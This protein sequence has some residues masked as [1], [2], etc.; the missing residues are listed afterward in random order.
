[1]MIIDKNNS[2]EVQVSQPGN[3]ETLFPNI[4]EEG[5]GGI[6]PTGTKIINITSN[7]TKT[8]NVAEYENVKINTSVMPIY[9]TLNISIH[10]NGITNYDVSRYRNISINVN[11]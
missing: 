10:K 6:T 8:E 11:V 3:V 4:D 2:G 5:G 1:M 7:G 9:D